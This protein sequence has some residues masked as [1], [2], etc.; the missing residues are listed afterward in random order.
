MSTRFK[1][2]TTIILTLVL[3]IASVPSYGATLRFKDVKEN[4][5]AY[6]YIEDMAVKGYLNGYPGGTFGPSSNLTFIEAMSALSKFAEATAAE[7]SNAVNGYEYLFSELK[8]NQN[9]EKEVLAVALFKNIIS[10]KELRDA[11]KGDMFNKSLNRERIAELIAKAMGLEETANAI[12]VVYVDFKD[13]SKVDSS[14]RKYLRVLLDANVLDPKGKGDQQFDP[15][16]TL[17]RAEMSTLM[18]RGYDYV[19]KTPTKPEVVEYEY[20][21]DTIKRV[22]VDAGT[23]LVIENKPNME[24]AYRIDDKTSITVDG[25]IAGISSL[26]EGQ[27]VKLKIKKDTISVVTLEAFTRDVTLKGVAKNIY[28]SDYKMIIE[29]KDENKT[30]VKEFPIDPNARIYLNDKIATLRDLKDGDRVELKVKSNI[31]TEI[32]ALSNIKQTAGIIKEIVPVKEADDTNYIITLEDKDKLDHKF[33]INFRTDL[34]R[35]NNFVRVDQLKVKDQATIYGEY[36][37]DGDRYIAKEIKADVVVTGVRGSISQIINSVNSNT[38]IT[39]LNRETGKDEVYELN[40]EAQIRVDGRV[41]SAADLKLRYQV[42]IVLE[43]DEI[44]SLIAESAA[45]VRNVLGKI[46]SI[47]HN[48][49]VMTLEDISYDSVNYGKQIMVYFTTN[50]PTLDRNL[51]KITSS[52]L[53]AGQTIIV[54]GTYNGANLDAANIQIR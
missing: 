21:T 20:I 32:L 9:W 2:T 14:K 16:S 28:S 24:K 29:Y 54:T 19:K 40:T 17:S 26:L 48:R 30:I 52:I 10:E 37:L 23:M 7:K 6:K 35:K 46:M 22:T 5:W 39:I 13:I 47:D 12:D 42:D 31:I 53:Q 34:Y 50:T 33:T 51:N 1:K 41:T 45:S 25:K 49:G 15:K 38:K 36:D 8:I 44:V 43:G 27:E 11:K 18:S 3:L 4:H